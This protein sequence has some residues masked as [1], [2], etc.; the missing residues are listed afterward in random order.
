MDYLGSHVDRVSVKDYFSA[1]MEN[2]LSVFEYI[3]AHLCTKALRPDRIML[4]KVAFI[5]IERRHNKFLKFAYWSGVG[6]GGYF[7]QWLIDKQ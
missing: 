7:H 1:T 5:P 3:V 2:L 6:E 4:S